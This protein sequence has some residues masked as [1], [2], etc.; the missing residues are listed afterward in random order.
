VRERGQGS[1]WRK[2]VTTA[3]FWSVIK[4]GASQGVVR[5]AKHTNVGLSHRAS[6]RDSLALR[7]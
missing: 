2:G 4:Q 5:D 6:L 3:Y 7:L 1:T